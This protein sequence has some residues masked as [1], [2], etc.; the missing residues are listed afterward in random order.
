MQ[1]F[2]NIS[3]Y[4]VNQNKKGHLF[5]IIS[6]GEKVSI[7]A[8]KT[9]HMKMETSHSGFH[10]FPSRKVNNVSI[11]IPHRFFKQE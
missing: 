6:Y 9:L 4:T 11:F 8:Q 10:F 2:I 5:L 7:D 3:L 1:K